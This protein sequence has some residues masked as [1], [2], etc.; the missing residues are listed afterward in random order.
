MTSGVSLS[1]C[2]S[3]ALTTEMPRKLKVDMMEAHHTGNPLTYLK[4][5]GKDQGH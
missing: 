1:V 3:R 5:K 2:L 4:V